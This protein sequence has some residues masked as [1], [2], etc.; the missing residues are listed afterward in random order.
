MDSVVNLIRFDS[1]ENEKKS[2]NGIDAKHRM[3]LRSGLAHTYN[4]SACDKKVGHVT[5]ARSWPNHDRTEPKIAGLKDRVLHISSST[6]KTLKAWTRPKINRL[7]C[8]D[9]RIQDNP[10]LPIVI[11]YNLI[12]Y[13]PSSNHAW[14]TPWYYLIYT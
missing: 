10:V 13:I 7:T 8:G 11:P 2:Q 3:R 5:Q 12:Y 9:W 14:F 1:K 4:I 6:S